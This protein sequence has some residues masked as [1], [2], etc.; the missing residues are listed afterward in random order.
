MCRDCNRIT[1]G[2]CGGGEWAKKVPRVIRHRES[3]GILVGK[4]IESRAHSFSSHYQKYTKVQPAMVTCHSIVTPSLLEKSRLEF[5]RG[6]TTLSTSTCGTH[7]TCP[8]S[9]MA[10]KM[11]LQPKIRTSNT[12]IISNGNHFGACPLPGNRRSLSRAGTRRR[13]V[14]MSYDL[15]Q[16]DVP[17]TAPKLQAR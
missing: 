8:S 3:M 5:F 17:I 4:V 1:S 6:R 16:D 11:Q 10:S 9:E 13:A 7:L 12:K 14:I 15:G 2:K